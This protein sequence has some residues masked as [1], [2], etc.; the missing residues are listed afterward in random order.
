MKENIAA[1][2]YLVFVILFAIGTKAFSQSYS[3]PV[4]PDSLK[5]RNSRITYM[6]QHYWDNADFSDSSLFAQ[7]KVVLDYIYLLRM[8]P[9]EERERCI[10][11]GVTAFSSQTHTA[12]YLLFWYERYL[13]N[14]QSPYYNDTTFLFIVN[15]LLELT[16]DE[17]LKNEL[18]YIKN[19]TQR[20]R[21]G[22]LA[23]DFFFI[24]KDGTEKRLFDIK[25]P[26]ILLVF[27]SPDCSLCHKLEHNIAT[28]DSIQQLITEKQLEIIAISPTA[29]YDE[30]QSHEYPANWTCGLDKNKTIIKEQLYE[31]K[32]YPS[33]YLLDKDMRVII[34][35]ADYDMLISTLFRE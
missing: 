5:D 28:N 35:E 11:N 26:L 6:A 25:A 23:E 33:I 14:P 17:G 31:L 8:L 24:L 10:N 22:G 16:T 34:K 27:N 32:Q 30:W 2:Y 19:T 9:I 13:H 20:N 15:A 7:P 3:Y 12:D 4:I 21:I 29:D 1:H 18:T